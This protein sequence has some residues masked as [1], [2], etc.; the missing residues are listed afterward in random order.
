MF[1]IYSGGMQ[2][3]FIINYE[4][5]MLKYLQQIIPVLYNS[6]GLWVYYF[7]YRVVREEK[8]KI[9]PLES[10]SCSEH[11]TRHVNPCDLFY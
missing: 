8:R 6:V 10:L 11:C 9:Y 2:D 3:I 4:I 7:Y 5:L 1:S